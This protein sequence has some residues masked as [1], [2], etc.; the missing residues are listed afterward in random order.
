MFFAL[1]FCLAFFCSWHF[2]RLCLTFFGKLEK[3]LVWRTHVA[4][5]FECY[6]LTRSCQTL[7]GSRKRSILLE[8]S[9]EYISLFYP[10]LTCPGDVLRLFRVVLQNLREAGIVPHFAP[11]LEAFDFD[12]LY[13][14]STTHMRLLVAKKLLKHL[15]RALTP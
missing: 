14:A 8:N 15:K 7:K 6:M 4:L 2:C 9:R 5:T 1:R 10:H 11:D 13:K 12:S 3:K